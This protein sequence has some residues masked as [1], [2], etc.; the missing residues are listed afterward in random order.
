VSIIEV[1]DLVKRY[2]DRPAVHGV[3]FTVEEGEIFGVLGPNGAGKT[4]TVEVIA[5]LRT[6][7]SGTIKV[8]G[9]DPRV[10][11][12][13]LRQQLGVQLQESE[14]PEQLKVWEALDLFASF[15]DRPANWEQLIVEL[16]LEQN[17]VPR[18]G[19][20]SGGQKQRPV[21]RPGARRQSQNRL[22]GIITQL[23]AMQ[24]SRDRE[25]APPEPDL[26][27]GLRPVG[28]RS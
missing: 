8:L 19:R 2:G 14:L 13:A 25:A 10:D 15:Y 26:R 18:S 11:R 21:C 12:A 24:Q 17:V 4:T 28:R 27:T 22:I 7:D 20:L 1:Q 3:S 16:G 6:P 23:E 9:L 5:G